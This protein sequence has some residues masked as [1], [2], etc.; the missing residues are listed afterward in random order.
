MGEGDSG[1][2]ADS[3]FWMLLWGSGGTA[4]GAQ[5]AKPQNHSQI[6]GREGKGRVCRTTS[7]VGGREGESL[8]CP[9][10][11]EI[12]GAAVTTNCTWRF[13]TTEASPFSV[14][15]TR[16]LKSRCSQHHTPFLPLL[17][18]RGS[19]CPWARGLLPPISPSVFTWCL[20]CV[21]LSPLVSLKDNEIDL[22]PL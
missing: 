20:L 22:G 9:L 14:L 10:P 8:S 2:R 19:R 3:L 1:N 4:T 15:E 6:R 7:P 17:A 13:Q 21:C 12:A 16:C 18:S 5:P 11:A